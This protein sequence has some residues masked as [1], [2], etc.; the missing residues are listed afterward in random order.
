MKGTNGLSKPLWCSNPGN[1]GIAEVGKDPG[2]VQSQECQT[3]IPELGNPRVGLEFGI[4][5]SLA[6]LQQLGTLWDGDDEEELTCS[7]RSHNSREVSSQD[8]EQIHGIGIGIGTGIRFGSRIGIGTGISDHQ[9]G[10]GPRNGPKL[11]HNP[12]PTARTKKR[13]SSLVCDLYLGKG[14]WEGTSHYPIRDKCPTKDVCSCSGIYRLPDS[15][16]DSS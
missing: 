7:K 6:E 1:S 11:N 15:D 9:P 10:C 13:D 14:L 8:K 2:G 3:L 4:S 16:S 5:L 12:H